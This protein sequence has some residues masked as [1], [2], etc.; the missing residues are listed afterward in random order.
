V[1][2]TGFS[3]ERWA[4][5]KALFSEAV[6]RPAS[7]R[8]AFLAEACGNDEA[9]RTEVEALLHAHDA[10]GD[11]FERRDTPVV[12]ALARAGVP[13]ASP[14][15]ATLQ[16]GRRLG[17]Y[18]IVERI[19]AGGMGQVYRAHDVR[20][21]RDVALKILPPA[22]VSDP[23]RRERF[24]QEARAASALEHP[25][26][27]RIHDIGEAD[28]V[29]Y[30][31][32]ELVRGESLADAI[33]R[34]PLAPIRAL[35]RAIEIA[36]AL[37]RAHDRG[38]VHRDL[39][40][41]NVMLTEDGHAAIIDFGLAKLI[42]TLSGERDRTQTAPHSTEGGMVL[43]TASYMSPEQA[44]GD[45]VDQRSDIFSFGIVLYEMLAGRVPFHGKSG[46]D[47][48]HAI[49]HE[50]APPLPPL[51]ASADLQRIVDK[52]LAKDP[53]ERYQ[54]MR[55]LAVDLRSARRR[56]ESGQTAPMVSS[57]K[58]SMPRYAAGV[59]LLSVVAVLIALWSRS[60]GAP[61]SQDRARWVQVTNLD[62]ATQPALSP[63]GRMLAFIRGSGATLLSDGQ[64]YLKLLPGGDPVPLTSDN[65]QK[66]APTFSPDGATV[67]YT[68]LDDDGQWNT[69]VVP[70]LRGEPR[71]WLRNASGLT[72]IAPDQLLFSEMKIGIHMGIATSPE[73]RTPSR[74]VYL[75][76]NEAGMAH[77]SYRSPDGRTVI[78]SEMDAGGRWLPCRALPFD[79]SSSGRAVGPLN[80]RCTI[81]AWSPDGKW[82]YFSADRGD[83]FHLWRQRFPDGPAEQ[84]T[85]GPT[86]EEGVAVAPDGASVI[87]SVGLRQRSVWIRT[88][89]GERQLSVEGYAFWPLASP[90]GRKVCYRVLHLPG[91]G[92]TP[93]ELWMTD[94]VSGERQRL[95]PGKLV[96]S[97]DLSADDRIV[98]AVSESDH[99]S[100]LWLQSLDGREPPHRIPNVDGDNPRFGAHGEILFRAPEGN[101]Y[102][103]TAVREDG[104]GRRRIALANAFV[105]GSASR[106]G[107]WISNWDARTLTLYSAIGR[108]PV[109]VF[110]G[111]VTSSRLRWTWDG[112]RAYWSFQYGDAA[113]FAEGHTYVL[114]VS[115]TDV[116]PPIPPG[117]FTSEAQIEAVPGVRVLPYG[118]VAPGPDPDTYVFSR[119]TITRNLYRIPLPSR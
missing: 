53:T 17:P 96:T 105:Y 10:A 77:R 57:P 70:A 74:N 50:P 47:T 51:V 90:H 40:P 26:I 89:E 49:L 102:A 52:C 1:S 35:D 67:A 55:D 68:A 91:S 59:L 97:Y 22:L 18:E 87:T 114:P 19:G 45:T 56:L 82:M 84:L 88:A 20:L 113:S 85:S 98:A 117:G 32:M 24:V 54:G 25:H 8:G 46:I 63:D 108:A 79:G 62:S 93:S 44:R 3:K 94:T 92:Q 12:S 111:P 27:A 101:R 107:Q 116:V 72:W 5:A 29:T 48:L 69:W 43:G 38:I 21:H 78:L 33:A 118:D 31:A 61:V 58:S 4:R 14:L 115:A 110:R 60:G 11:L 80:A 9:L 2:G 119:L 16:A 23:A 37:A 15:P 39:K 99:E 30:I 28:G 6:A 100:G 75:P 73:S 86:E 76:D 41:A 65:R 13:A 71:R 106:D 36:E 103:L 83:G 95:L 66:T 7:E 64:I 34:G 109:A 81:A 112:L 104:S 42:E